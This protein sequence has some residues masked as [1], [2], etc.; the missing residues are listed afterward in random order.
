MQRALRLTSPCKGQG[1]ARGTS[2]MQ[3]AA[4]CSWPASASRPPA[5]QPAPPA[6]QPTPAQ[7]PQQKLTIGFVEIDGDPRY[8]PIRGFERL[9]LKTHEHPFAGAQVGIDEAAALARVLKTDF[10]LERITVKSAEEVAPAVQQALEARGIHFFLI[11]APAEA[12]K[13]LAAAVRGRDALL[14]NVSAPDDSLRRDLC[15]RRNSCTPC[16]ASP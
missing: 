15:A 14:F 12:F 9:I 2:R 4:H 13:P 5:Q 3:S 8:E 16:R 10:V 7:Q 1:F 11:D 6:Q